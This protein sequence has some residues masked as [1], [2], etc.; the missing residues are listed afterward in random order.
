MGLSKCSQCET[1]FSWSQVSTSI[2]FCYQP[3][4][5]KV[6]GTEGRIEY[7]SRLIGSMIVFPIWIIGFFIL[8]LFQLSLQKTVLLL[9]LVGILGILIQP[10][11]MTY[12]SDKNKTKNFTF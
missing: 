8:P 6:C 11:F 5:C 3:I 12:S 10:F 1:S 4:L 9:L 2:W 7:R